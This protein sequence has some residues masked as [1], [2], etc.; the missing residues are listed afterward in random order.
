MSEFT[1]DHEMD[2]RRN[3]ILEIICRQSAEFVFA[4][5]SKLSTDIQKIHQGS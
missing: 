4:T 3:K 5:E 1:V 2:W